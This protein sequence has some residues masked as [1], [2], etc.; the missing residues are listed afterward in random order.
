MPASATRSPSWSCLAT[1]RWLNQATLNARPLSSRTMASVSLIR[2]CFETFASIDCTVPTTV[3]WV[4]TT[5]LSMGAGPPYVSQPKG[6]VSSRSR[7]VSI[8]SLSSRS[9]LVLPMSGNADTGLSRAWGRARIRADTFSP[10]SRYLR[11]VGYTP[12]SRLT[13]PQLGGALRPAT[14]ASHD[15]RGRGG[16]RHRSGGNHRICSERARLCGNP[17][18]KLGPNFEPGGV[19]SKRVKCHMQRHRY[20]IRCARTNVTFQPT[21]GSHPGRSIRVQFAGRR[22]DG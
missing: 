17:H 18:L 22:Q 19:A 6:R 1:N 15:D 4:P 16:R 10:P 13:T 2:F 8:P 21:T 11:Q 20:Q 12:A 9:A 14:G 7:I 3:A 5:R